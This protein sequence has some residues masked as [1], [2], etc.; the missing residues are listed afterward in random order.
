MDFQ[1]SPDPVFAQLKKEIEEHPRT[2]GTYLID[3]VSIQQARALNLSDDHI[4]DELYC[5]WSKTSELIHPVGAESWTPYE[6]DG[7]DD[8]KEMMVYAMKGGSAV[9]HTFDTIPEAKALDFAQRFLQF[10]ARPRAFRGMGIGDPVY[11]LE[12]GV[13][14]LDHDVAGILLVMEND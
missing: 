6:M 9:G 5:W 10:F 14:L 2:C 13:L 1:T 8:I 4:L 11:L 7:V 12:E 3:L